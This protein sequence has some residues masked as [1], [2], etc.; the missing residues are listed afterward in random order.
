MQTS[1]VTTDITGFRVESQSN[2]AA[3][4]MAVLLGRKALLEAFRLPGADI[5]MMSR[6]GATCR[7]FACSGKMSPVRPI[8]HGA[9]SRHYSSDLKD[10]LHVRHLDGEDKGKTAQLPHEHMRLEKPQSA[11]LNSREPPPP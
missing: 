10:E 4:S 1:H 8:V 5:D 6:L 7:L 3:G 11:I 9:A 2:T